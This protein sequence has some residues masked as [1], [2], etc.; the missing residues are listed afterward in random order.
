MKLTGTCSQSEFTL[1]VEPLSNSRVR[2][3]LDNVYGSDAATTVAVLTHAQ[4]NE[5]A[6]ILRGFA[7]QTRACTKPPPGWRCTRERGHEGPCAAWPDNG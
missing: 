5:L 1:S 7:G 2:I 6:D 3:E 4:A